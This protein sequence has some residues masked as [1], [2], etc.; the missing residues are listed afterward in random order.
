MYSL[1]AFFL[2]KVHANKKKHTFQS[3]RWSD[4][5]NTA[6]PDGTERGVG[7]TFFARWKGE[8]K[9]SQ[10]ALPV[11]FSFFKE[12]GAIKERKALPF[13]QSAPTSWVDKLALLIARRA[14]AAALPARDMQ[15]V[16]T[17]LEKG[18]RRAPRL[19][20]RKRPLN[21]RLNGHRATGHGTAR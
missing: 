16:P 5:S 18:N 17:G 4:I 13:P 7:G 20:C 10:E 15:F 3:Q 19:A 12:S 11:P 6:I 2:F 9:F 1:G 14:L 8:T 21:R